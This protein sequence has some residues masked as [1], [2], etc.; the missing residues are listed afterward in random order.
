MP[1][2]RYRGGLEVVV[3]LPT[4]SL[5]VAPG[6]EFDA[7]GD[8]AERLDVHPDFEAAPAAKKAPAKKAGATSPIT[9]TKG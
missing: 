1:K 8:E 7:T 4:R 6:D 9:E 5:T 3:V 2:Y